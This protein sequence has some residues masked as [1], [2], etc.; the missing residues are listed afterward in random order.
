MGSLLNWEKF[1]NDMMEQIAGFTEVYHGITPTEN[2]EDI[3]IDH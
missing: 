1:S 3:G 2:Q